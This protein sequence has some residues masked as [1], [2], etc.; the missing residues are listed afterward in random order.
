MKTGSF[1]RWLNKKNGSSINTIPP[2]S[3]DELNIY[4]NTE[5][6]SKLGLTIFLTGTLGFLI[7]ASF[8]PLTEGVP[9]EGNVSIDTKR[10]KVQHLEGGIIKE[11]L[12]KEGEFVKKGDA[13]IRL[14]NSSVKAEF[15]SMRQHYFQLIATKC[16]LE[17]EQTGKKLITFSP[18]IISTATKDPLIKKLL[19]DQKQLMHSRSEAMSASIKIFNESIIGQ[20][21]LS[22]GFK[23]IITFRRNQL[24]SFLKELSGIESLVLEGY[25]PRTQQQSI[26]R[27]I[28][29]LH[30]S[31]AELKSSVITARQKI[32]ELKQRKIQTRFNFLEDVD[33]KL[34]D[35]GPQIQPTLETY[36]IL[37]NKLSR[38]TIKAPA[39]GQVVSLST[40]TVGEV[41]QS[42][43]KLMDIVPQKEKLLIETKIPPHLVDRVK[44]DDLVDVR[45][46]TF[47][48]SPLLV[49]SGQLISLSEDVLTD[50]KSN[51]NYY[52]ARIVI[53]QQ[54][55]KDLGKRKMHAGMPAQVIIKTGK[56]SLLTFLLNPLVK[57]IS[58]SM[59]EE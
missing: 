47:S 48:H 18:E 49:V 31:I 42:G 3:H 32:L 54:G 6:I 4:S 26:E 34:A 19:L 12:V 10:K 52:L 40:Q 21:S 20:E 8:A 13:L 51:F 5:S 23:K 36:K 39:S 11:V 44:I 41:I 58:A 15:K 50:D 16:R 30:S 17:A 22:L 43:Q 25:A 29:D 14:A 7:W 59:Q 53:T 27:S 33:S 46:S 1:K 28:A 57:R 45:F 24:N 37:F 55:I 9:T 56:R 38:T 2:S 35:I